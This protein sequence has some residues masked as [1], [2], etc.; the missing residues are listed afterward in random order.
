M[1][2]E[3]GRDLVPADVRLR[4]AVQE[5]QWWAVAAGAREDPSTR[6]V[7]E[8]RCEARKQVRQF[9][10]DYASSASRNGRVRSSSA[11]G[12]SSG[13]K[14]PLSIGPPERRL[15]QGSHTDSGSAISTS[16]P[17]VAQTDMDRAFDAGAGVA[18]G[19]VKKLVGAVFRAI[20]LAGGVDAIR[21]RQHVNIVGE[22]H[23]MDHRGR[24][25]QCRPAKAAFDPIGGIFNDQPL[26]EGCRLRQEDAVQHPELEAFLAE[27]RDVERRD[28]VDQNETRD[29]LGRIEGEPEGDTRAAIVPH[30][31]EALEVERCH[32]LRHV[33]GHRAL[34]VGAVVAV[35]RGAVAAAVAAQI[36]RYHS[37]VLGQG[38]RHAV[39][40]GVGLGIPVQQEKRWPAPADA[41]EN[42]DAAGRV[43]GAR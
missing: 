1:T 2:C 4:I 7:D 8:V 24:F 35:A 5:Q 41:G 29:A 42:L 21:L 26:G 27:P 6:H 17:W 31:A 12:F 22:R 30:D 3:F 23:R 34:G 32:Q 37:E 15:H 19:F 20:V 10:H 13:M 9:G 28:D 40:H 36:G 18:V 14:C 39:P 33:E 25:R 16:E 11:P 43:R 38:R